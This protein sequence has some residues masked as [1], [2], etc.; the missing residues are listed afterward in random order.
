[1]DG[2]NSMSWNKNDY[3]KKRDQF[4][5][6]PPTPEYTPRRQLAIDYEYTITENDFHEHIPT[7]MQ[8]MY[9]ESGLISQK[10]WEQYRRLMI[11]GIEVL[12]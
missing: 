8:F 12:S 2:I 6:A 7:D 3:K 5:E 11:R 10:E 1:M 9:R 4:G